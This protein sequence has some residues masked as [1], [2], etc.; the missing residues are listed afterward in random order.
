MQILK[1]ASKI[2]FIILALTACGAFFFGKLD[3]DQFMILAVSAFSFYFSNKGEIAGG[4]Y[5]GK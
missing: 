5:A 1:S 2:V 3:Q 4:D